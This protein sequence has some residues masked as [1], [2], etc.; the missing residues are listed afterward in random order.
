L[1]IVS[2]LIKQELWERTNSAR[3]KRN[4]AKNTEKRANAA[5]SA[6]TLMNARSWLKNIIREGN[7]PLLFRAGVGYNVHL[8]AVRFGSQPLSRH[9]SDR[10]WVVSGLWEIGPFAK[11]EL[12]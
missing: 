10:V 2:D 3:L 8:Y 9:V 7:S 11:K 6:L 1:I 4:A 5:K 12:S